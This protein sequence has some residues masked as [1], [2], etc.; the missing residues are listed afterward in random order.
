MR[1]LTSCFQLRVIRL[2][3]FED[4]P[5]ARHRGALASA[6]DRAG[7]LVIGE[8]EVQEPLANAPE[9]SAR[10]EVRDHRNASDLTSDR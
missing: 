6:P 2:L 8:L 5:G 7:L 9:P 4:V 10:T 3:A 1:P